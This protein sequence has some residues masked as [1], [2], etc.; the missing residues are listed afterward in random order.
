MTHKANPAMVNEDGLTALQI[1]EQ[2]KKE[3]IISYFAEREKLNICDSY[4][5]THLYRACR[6]GELDLI[7]TLISYNADVNIA[8]KNTEITPLCKVA[9]MI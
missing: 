6:N 7:K 8:E 2:E 4:G 1:A 5:H 3:D 9:G